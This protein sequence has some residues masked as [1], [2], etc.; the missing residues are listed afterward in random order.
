MALLVPIYAGDDQIGALLLGPKEIRIPYTEEDFLLLEDVADQLG[1][2]ILAAQRQEE[3]A[4]LISEM[5]GD[6]RDREHA[7][8][9][10]M[11]QMMAEQQE[12]TRPVLEGLDDKSFAALV[13][14]ALRRLYDFT[15]LGEHDMARLSIV[16]WHLKNGD[17]QFVTSIDRGKAV[18]EILVEAVSKL[19]PE[20]N[21]P[22]RYT[23]PPREWR[24][25]TILHDAYVM[26]ELNRDIMSKLYIG[27]GTFNRTRRRAVRGVARALRE[28]EWEVQ[29]KASA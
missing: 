18:S 22:E 17:D 6:F 20:G 4:S 25:F 16:D 9:R 14:D 10:Q 23:V 24:Q 8:Q 26:G 28:M 13:E 19:R 21:A 15:Y 27:E 5:V 2:L 11:Q 1:T 3:N 7:L 12:Q 29:K